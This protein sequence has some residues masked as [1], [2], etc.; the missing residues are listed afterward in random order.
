MTTNH[1][2]PRARV[3]RSFVL[4]PFSSPKCR[5]RETCFAVG[6]MWDAPGF[7]AQGFEADPSFSVWTR[8]GPTPDRA[9]IHP[10]LNVERLYLCTPSCFASSAI[11]APRPATVIRVRTPSGRPCS[12]GTLD[13]TRP[14]T[15]SPERPGTWKRHLVSLRKTWSH[16]LYRW[17]FPHGLLSGLGASGT[18]LLLI[19]VPEASLN[20]CHT[21]Q[22]LREDPA[23][24]ALLC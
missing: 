20:R 8:L 7:H 4:F 21:R 3:G 16:V 18:A 5:Y 10:S 19:A 23:R 24:R 15:S 1:R 11:S 9:P 14:S 22:L 13:I 6:W 12:W 2:P 17:K